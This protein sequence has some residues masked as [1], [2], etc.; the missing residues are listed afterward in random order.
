[1]LQIL[2]IVDY[3]ASTSNPAHYRLPPKLRNVVRILTVSSA[4]RSPLLH[5]NGG[6]IVTSWAGIQMLKD[7]LGVVLSPTKKSL[8]ILQG[9]SAMHNGKP[10]V[11]SPDPKHLVYSRPAIFMYQRY[12]ERWLRPNTY[13]RPE[14]LDHRH[15]RGRELSVLQEALDEKPSFIA[16]DI[17][18]LR[19]VETKSLKEPHDP[20]YFGSVISLMNYTFVYVDDKANFRYVTFTHTINNEDEWQAAKLVVDSEYP[21]VMHNGQYDSLILMRWDLAPRNYIF[22]T[23]Y[24]MRSI[25]PFLFYSTDKAFYSLF[26]VAGFYLYENPYWKEDRHSNDFASFIKYGATDAMRTAM[27][28]VK[29]MEMMSERTFNNFTMSMA[30]VPACLMAEIRGLLLDMPVRKQLRDEYAAKYEQQQ[31]LFKELTGYDANSQK[32]KELTQALFK[33]YHKYLPINDMREIKSADKLAIQEIQRYDPLIEYVFDVCRDVRR[34]SKWLSTFINATYWSTHLNGSE[35]EEQQTFVFSLSPFA[36]ISRRFASRK[37]SFWLGSNIQNVPVPLRKMF[38]APEGYT[39]FSSDIPA[40]E[41]RTSAVAS[42]NKALWDAVSGARDYHSDNAAAFFAKRYEDIYDDDNH[43]KL[44]PTLR[45]LAKRVG[46]GATY[47]MRAYMLLLTMGIANVRYVQK[48]MNL[49]AEWKPTD[50]TKHL[51]KRFDAK[52]EGLRTTWYAKQVHKICTT[53][54]L[55]TLTGYAPLFVDSPIDNHEVLN[56]A[57][58]LEP[59]HISARISIAMFRQMLVAELKGLPIKVLF[60]LHDECIGLVQKGVPIKQLDAL[61]QGLGE[62]RLVTNW[63]YVPVLIMPVGL[64]VLGKN[65]EEISADPNHNR[66]GLC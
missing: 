16:I 41:T 1:M 37:S 28:A 65:W 58:S 34:T 31:K 43:K 35:V 7:T 13:M 39:M 50:V 6:I 36:T 47:N 40:A 62:N 60:Q 55:M 5:K 53:G 3:N 63:D 26:H 22:D 10:I 19:C 8:D 48:V 15:L 46:H 2:L 25:T 20:I 61:L 54:R 45:E 14:M 4:A 38:K 12:V 11:V 49:P 51:L 29:Q 56:T 30:D 32:L 17:E 27:I 33:F 21:K 57:A 24:V 44:D 52:Y 18:T 42:Q 66:E 9:A 59:Q 23:M 64:P